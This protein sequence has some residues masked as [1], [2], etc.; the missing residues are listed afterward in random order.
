MSASAFRTGYWTD[1]L[2]GK[3]AISFLTD[4]LFYVYDKYRPGKR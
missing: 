2:E 4:K 3:E 1:V